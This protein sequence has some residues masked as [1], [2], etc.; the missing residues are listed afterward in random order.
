MGVHTYDG[1]H[2][3]QINSNCPI[4][5]VP[6]G[7][8]RPPVFHRRSLGAT[9]RRHPP[10]GFGFTR[11]LSFS[12]PVRHLT[13]GVPPPIAFPKKISGPMAWGGGEGFVL[14]GQGHQPCWC[15]TYLIV[16]PIHLDAGSGA[17]GITFIIVR[18]A[19][20]NP[21]RYCM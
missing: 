4:Q 11:R 16:L 3:V 18:G 21:V 19:G 2:F 17:R 10:K 7:I 9:D 1:R 12:P 5:Q 8:Q 20:I 14:D 15:V 13:F 6:Y